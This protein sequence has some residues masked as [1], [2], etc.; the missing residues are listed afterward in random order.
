M[1]IG[2]GQQEVPSHRTRGRVAA[3]PSPDKC[4]PSAGPSHLMVDTAAFA[5]DTVRHCGARGSSAGNLTRG[6]SSKFRGL[7][8]ISHPD[9][10]P[11][12]QLDLHSGRSPVA[13]AKSK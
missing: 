12:F 4:A 8:V 1:G 10:C 2:T 9:R 5:R 3:P 7:S 13:N 6:S 11:P